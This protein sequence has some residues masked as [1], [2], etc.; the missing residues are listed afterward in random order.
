MQNGETA[1]R[2]NTTLEAIENVWLSSN[3]IVPPHAGFTGGFVGTP[4]D[5]VNVRSA[6]SVSLP[7]NNQT[8]HNAGVIPPL[9]MSFPLCL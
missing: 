8:N 9:M 7:N 2:M 4:A 1:G 5:M 6:C 3:D